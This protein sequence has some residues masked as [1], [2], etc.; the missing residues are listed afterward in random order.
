MTSQFVIANAFWLKVL[1][2]FHCDGLT[3][4]WGTV[5]LRPGG[6]DDLGLIVHEQVHLDQIKR[7]GR[8]KFTVLYLW[9]LWRYG[10]FESPLEQEAYAAQFAVLGAISLAISC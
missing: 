10:Y 8:V 5:Y 1:D 3:M 4:P 7:L 6:L 9:Y 2:T